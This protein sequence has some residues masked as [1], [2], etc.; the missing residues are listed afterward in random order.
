[1]SG[2]P[3]RSVGRGGVGGR[4]P[5]LEADWCRRELSRL[6]KS[7]VDSDQIQYLLSIELRRDVQ[8]YLEG[9]L[10]TEVCKQWCNYKLCNGSWFCVFIDAKLIFLI[11]SQN[12]AVQNFQREFFHRWH[13][14]ERQPDWPSTEGAGSMKPLVRVKDEEMFLFTAHKQVEQVR[15]TLVAHSYRRTYLRIFQWPMVANFESP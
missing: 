3:A 9:L 12:R 15:H 1:M 8:E 4:R 10:G 13:P 5:P 2:V 11:F 7:P 14:P 6:L